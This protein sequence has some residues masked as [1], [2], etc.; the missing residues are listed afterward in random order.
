MNEPLKNKRQLEYPDEGDHPSE[1]WFLV[2]DV[3]SAVEWLK[4]KVIVNFDD[5]GHP[6]LSDKF[7]EWINQAFEDVKEM[8][9]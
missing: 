4:H 2:G 9:D 5:A 1:D 6:G 7:C 3:A 8:E